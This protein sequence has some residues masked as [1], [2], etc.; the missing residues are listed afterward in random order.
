MPIGGTVWKTL[1]IVYNNNQ[2][3]YFHFYVLSD[4]IFL[5]CCANIQ[6]FGKHIYEIKLTLKKKKLLLTLSVDAHAVVRN[7]RER[8]HL[9]LIQFSSMI[10]FS[11]TIVQYHHLGVNSYTI[12]LFYSD[13]PS[14]TCT[15]A[16]FYAI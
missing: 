13:V 15:C 4:D 5:H 1:P 3:H 11:K 9:P 8:A 6:K 16:Y 10:I 14:F 7:N 2:E 12:H